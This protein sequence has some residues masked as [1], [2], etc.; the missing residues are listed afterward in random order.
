MLPKR[1]L[2]TYKPLYQTCKK[3][4]LV[5]IKLLVCGSQRVSIVPLTLSTVYNIFCVF[6]IS[7]IK[8]VYINIRANFKLLLL[9][10]ISK[11]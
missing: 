5:L 2:K 10:I 1:I 11:S 7:F 8:F 9:T 4:D 3:I 6:I